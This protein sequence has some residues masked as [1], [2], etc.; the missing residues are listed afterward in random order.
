[1]P[2]NQDLQAYKF[3]TDQTSGEFGDVRLDSNLS[4][5]CNKAAQEQTGRDLHS[6][7]TLL[8]GHLRLEKITI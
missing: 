4:M 5:E 3:N 6:S 1:M 2:Q 8:F 7:L